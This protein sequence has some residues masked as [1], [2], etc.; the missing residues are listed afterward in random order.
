MPPSDQELKKEE[1]ER[2]KKRKK[3]RAGGGI[4]T[5]DLRITNPLRYH[6]ATPAFE[7]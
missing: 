7:S 5:H 4:R 1:E 6:C 2:E 3:E